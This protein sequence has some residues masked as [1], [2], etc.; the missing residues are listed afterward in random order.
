MVQTVSKYQ[1]QL[2]W[3][4]L[5]YVQERGW[6]APEYW[7]DIV[8][9]GGR[10]EGR[11]MSIVNNIIETT[12]LRFDA[13]KYKMEAYRPE[14]AKEVEDYHSRYWEQLALRKSREWFSNTAAFAHL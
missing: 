4:L 10:D 8:T 6:G 12:N 9:R 1:Y 13:I 2:A 11:I 14:W 3:A 7:I 5:Y